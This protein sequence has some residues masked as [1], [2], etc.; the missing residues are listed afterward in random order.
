MTNNHNDQAA[1]LRNMQKNK[2]LNSM[3]RQGVC[4]IAVASGKGGVGKTFMSVNLAVAFAKLNKKVLLLDADLGLANADIILGVNSKWTIQD[5]IFKGMDLKS[6]VAKSEYGVDLLSASSGSKEMM[7]LGSVRMN[8][9]IKELIDF[10][11]EYDILIF[12]CAAGIEASVMSFIA[13]APQN[14][15]VATPQPTSVMDVYAL[16]KMIKQDNLTSKVSLI[17]NQVDSDKQGA[18]VAE[19]L[20]KVA[21]LHLSSEVKL[22]GIIPISKDVR[23]AIR[24]RKPFIEVYKDHIISERIRNIAKSI[25]QNQDS[26]SNKFEPQK[27]VDGFL[28]L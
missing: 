14:I 8:A 19:T 6:V 23:S 27:L 28:N 16:L 22:Q 5:A 13:A 2:S 26:K 25:L 20:N 7:S 21:K 3:S 4:C 24:Q 10:S 15:I 11:T 18:Q 12:D 1:S 9:F 17:I